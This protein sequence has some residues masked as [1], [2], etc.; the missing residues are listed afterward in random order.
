[1]RGRRLIVVAWLAGGGLAAFLLVGCCILPFHGFVHRLVPLCEMA[2]ALVTGDDTGP[3]HDHDHPAAPAERQDGS[4]SGARHQAGWQPAAHRGLQVVLT[5]TADRPLDSPARYRTLV[6]LGAT[7]L[8]EDVGARLA[9]L[10]T[11]RI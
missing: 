11:L 9:A 1:M 7:R 4:G 5:P 6:S 2:A 10:D 8:D 3:G